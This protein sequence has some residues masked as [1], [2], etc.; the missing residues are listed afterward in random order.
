M[1]AIT[2]EL[3]ALLPI[4]YPRNPESNWY[5]ILDLFGYELDTIQ[6]ST[7]RISSWHSIDEA[8]GKALEVVGNEYGVT[9]TTIDD[10]FYRFL[11]KSHIEMGLRVG[12]VN[13]LIHVL[14]NTS[15][16]DASAFD[17]RNGQEPM[18]VKVLNM[19]TALTPDENQRQLVIDWIEAVLPAGVRLEEISFRSASESEI[20]LGMVIESASWF[21]SP[22]ATMNVEDM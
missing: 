13:D 19:P 5:K 18:S 16:L 8:S 6:K 12:T 4:S 15:G 17:V 11:I 9:R 22:V 1:T 10:E 14:S 2:D 3:V 7:L 20:G 21:K